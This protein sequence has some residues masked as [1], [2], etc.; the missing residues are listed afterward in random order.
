MKSILH[1]HLYLELHKLI[2]Q[3]LRYKPELLGL[4]LNREGWVPIVALVSGILDFTPHKVSLD[5]I[6]ELLDSSPDKRFIKSSCGTLVKCA[7]YGDIQLPPSTPPPIL[8]Y[9]ITYSS[10]LL[11]REEGILPKSHSDYVVSY[12][13]KS[14]AVKSPHGLTKY[15]ILK[16]VTP[17]MLTRGVSFYNINDVTWQIDAPV[18]PRDIK[19]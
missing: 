19:W 14:G 13:D 6:I 12:G 3:A 15:I 9:P 1:S 7:D 4:Q 18:Q 10:A 16:I 2:S 17:P 5:N 11:A 8:Y